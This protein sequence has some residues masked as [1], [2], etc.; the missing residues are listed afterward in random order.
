MSTRTKRLLIGSLGL[1]MTY[2]ATPFFAGLIG[3][4]DCRGPKIFFEG[5]HRVLYVIGYSL[6]HDDKPRAPYM[7]E[8]SWFY[9]SVGTTIPKRPNLDPVQ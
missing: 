8:R 5:H 4:Y 2:W 3:T 7:Y 9:G 1:V 6:F